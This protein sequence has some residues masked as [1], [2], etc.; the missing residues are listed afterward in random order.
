M[1]SVLYSLIYFQ[2]L[3]GLADFVR[4]AVR[5][6]I[7]ERV[8]F[9]WSIMKY[10]VILGTLVLVNLVFDYAKILIVKQQ[11]RSSILAILKAFRM[12]AAHPGRMVGLY[13][14]IG[15]L[16]ISFFFLYSLVAPGINQQSNL[17]VGWACIVKKSGAVTSSHYRERSEMQSVPNHKNSG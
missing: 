1:A 10:L 5:D 8:A 15:L 3:A 6:Q 11:R 17:A 16:G 14:W 9:L 13:V 12:L 4:M 2:L 7:D